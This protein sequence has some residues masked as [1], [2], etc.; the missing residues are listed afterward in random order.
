[1]LLLAAAAACRRNRHCGVCIR[2]QIAPFHLA[3]FPFT[4]PAPIN[5][6]D[7]WEDKPIQPVGAPKANPFSNL[8]ASAGAINLIATHL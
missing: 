6:S 3:Q 8:A 5:M 7:S 1:L 2:F 4:P